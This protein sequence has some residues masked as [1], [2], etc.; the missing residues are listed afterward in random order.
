M[1]EK[2]HSSLVARDG[3]F[4]HSN[5]SLLNQPE[6]TAVLAERET[7]PKREQF[8]W[9]KSRLI[10]AYRNLY[11][12]SRSRYLTVRALDLGVLKVYAV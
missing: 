11:P 3:P 5:K 9:V 10:C 12:L 7:L 1:Q 8:K 6:V 2:D 4:R